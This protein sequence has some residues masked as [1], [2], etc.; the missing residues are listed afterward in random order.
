VDGRRSRGGEEGRDRTRAADVEVDDV[1]PDGLPSSDADVDR[2]VESRY[3]EN[4]RK[5]RSERERRGL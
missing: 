4:E 3:R 2:N 1:F 5:I